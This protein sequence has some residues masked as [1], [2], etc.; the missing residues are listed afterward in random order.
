VSFLAPDRLWLLL[1]PAAAVVGYLVMLRRKQRYALRYSDLELI[2]K[3]APDRPGW[4]RHIPAIGFLLAIGALVLSLARPVTAVQ[5]PQEQAMVVVAIDV[6]LSMEADDV[7]PS[8]IEAAQEAALNFVELAPEELRIG[9]VGFAGVALPAVAP[10]TDRDSV[11]TAIERLTLAEGTAV[12]EA[13]AASVDLIAREVVE[14]EEIPA[15]VVLLSDG[16]TTMGRS[17]EEAA[18]AAADAEIP[19][20]T[21]SFGTDDGTIVFQGE[22]VPVPPDE[23]ALRDVADTTGGRFFAAASSQELQQILD[24]VGSEVGFTTED[25]ELWEWFLLAGVVILAL[26]GGASLIWFSRLP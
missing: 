26:A 24:D 23:A 8:R 18:L 13:I 21:I 9:I 20:S 16:T 5:V 19:V 15:A 14:D 1:L 4:R 22:V 12:G 25:R 17:P 3:V 11:R 10:T 6:S 2:D 7:A